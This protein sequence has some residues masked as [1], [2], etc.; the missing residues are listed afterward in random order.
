MKRIIVTDEKGT[1]LASGP[2]PADTEARTDGGPTQWGYTPLQ[3]QRVHLVDVGR[4]ESIEDLERL[5]KTQRVEGTGDQA[6]LVA[7]R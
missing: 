7:V 4:V 2:D 3:G 6:R 5:H 1:I